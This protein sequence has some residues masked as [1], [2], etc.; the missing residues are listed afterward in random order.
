MLYAPKRNL[1]F[2]HCMKTGG[3]SVRAWWEET[4]AGE[5]VR[6]YRQHYHES[7]ADKMYA[8]GRLLKDVN[9]FTLIRNPYAI[10]VSTYHFFQKLENDPRP[11]AI[12]IRNMSWSDYISR[13]V[14]MA[15]RKQGDVPMSFW[16][17]FNIDGEVP[18]NLHIIRLEEID[19]LPDII[20]LRFGVRIPVNIPFINQSEHDS[21][22]S[23]YD[24]DTAA[25]IRRLYK[26]TFD[27]G[28]YDADWRQA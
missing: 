11:E 27:K 9:I 21:I 12:E 4:F 23:Y 2:L 1:A 10:P 28:Y 14:D 3:T 15:Y 5:T 25:H 16:D 7:L 17:Y 13:F 6:I 26:W 20:N 19:T 24:D 8:A 18:D 22:S